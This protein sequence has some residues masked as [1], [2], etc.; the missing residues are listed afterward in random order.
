MIWPI[1]FG[2]KMLLLSQNFKT[3]PVGGFVEPRDQTLGPDQK[4]NCEG[5]FS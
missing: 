4:S 5:D 2:M 1:D 3:S